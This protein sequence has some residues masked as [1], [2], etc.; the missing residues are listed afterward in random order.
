[1]K[2]YGLVLF[3]IAVIW[4]FA[5]GIAGSLVVDTALHYKTMDEIDQTMWS[6]SGIWYY[7]W[8]FGVP[9]SLLLAGMGVLF[10]S[11]AKKLT[12]VTFKTGIFL[13]VVVAM[14]AGAVGHIRPL[15]GLGGTLILLCFFGILWLW[16]KERMALEGPTLAADLRLVGYVFMAIAAWFICGQTSLPFLKAFEGQAAYTPLHIMILLVLGWFFLFMSH[17]KSRKT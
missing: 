6:M 17:L 13:A 1:V 4:A 16:A 2:K 3:C 14:F 8:A 9:L 15:F 11:G 10:Y 5:W 7:V 12:V